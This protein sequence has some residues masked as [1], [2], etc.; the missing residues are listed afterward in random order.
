MPE[1]IPS[2]CTHAAH[3]I[4]PVGEDA[5]EIVARNC[6]HEDNDDALDRLLCRTC[7][8]LVVEFDGWLCRVPDMDGQEI[9]AKE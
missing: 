2:S 9:A 4:A 5:F 1:L 3:L 7:G 8:A 6:L